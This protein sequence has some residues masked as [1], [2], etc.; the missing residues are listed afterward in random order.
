QALVALNHIPKRRFQR[1]N[2][3]FTPQ[4]YRQRHRVG[5]AQ[6]FQP[7]EEPQPALRIRQRY[8]ARPHN[9]RHRR[10]RR[11]ALAKFARQTRNRRRLEQ[12]ADRDL[13][14]QCHPDA[15]DQ[16]RRQQRVPPQRKEI[17]LDP[18][19][20]EPKNLRKQPAQNLLGGRARRAMLAP[21]P[22]FGRRQR[23]TVELA[24]RRQR[25]AI[26]N[27]NRSRNHV[28][29]QHP[30]DMRAQPSRLRQP[31]SR[32]RNHVSYQPLV[33]RL[34]LARNNRSLPHTSMPPQHRL[35]LARLNPKAPHLNLRVRTPDKLQHTLR[36][37]ARQ[38]PGPAH[39]PP[40][41]PHAHPHKPLAGQP[42]TPHVAA[43]KPSSRNIKLP[44]DPNRYRLQP[45]V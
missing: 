17:V 34:I 35:D 43:R 44:N 31:P 20:I 30:T 26:Q 41:Q 11:L 3:Q 14:T 1:R 39:P 7:V 33:P 13:H 19:P 12:A 10:T 8:L 18:N 27:N 21:G 25:Q 4:P 22:Q 40:T 37:P 2:V 36:T 6:S 32:R 38:V 16:P 29:R 42:Q 5:R 9:R 28:L 24:V 45:T 15:A 23:S